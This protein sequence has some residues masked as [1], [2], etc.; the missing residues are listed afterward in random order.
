MWTD[1]MTNQIEI[2][3]DK[4]FLKEKRKFKRKCPSIDEDFE[5]FEKALK[6]DL[7]DNDYKIPLDTKKYSK[8]SGLDKNVTLPVFVAKVFY[9]KK[10]NKG[11]KSGFR[12]SFIYDQDEYY[13]YFVEFYFKQ[14]NEI[15]NKER[16]N[17]LFK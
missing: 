12:I 6:V 17:R 15:E 5:R 4:R 8:I 2:G 7:K 10:M 14:S 1:N 16:I 3:Y 9:C 11:S 13:I